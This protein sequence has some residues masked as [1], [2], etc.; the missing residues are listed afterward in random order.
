MK[1]RASGWITILLALLSWW[2]IANVFATETAGVT[3]LIS[4]AEKDEAAFRFYDLAE[5]KASL[6]VTI[7]ALQREIK[8]L[9]EERIPEA[10]RQE[11]AALEAQS[12]I[13]ELEK[14]E[15]DLKTQLKDPSLSGTRPPDMNAAAKRQTILAELSEVQLELRLHKRANSGGADSSQD[16]SNQLNKKKQELS[17]AEK[18]LETVQRQ[19]LR[20]TTPEQSFKA[21]ISVY[22]AGLI[23]FVILGFFFTALWDSKVRQSVFAGQAGIQF[24]AL[25]SII[26]AII[27]FGITGIL[28]GNELAALLGSISGYILGKVSNP[29]AGANGVTRP[30]VLVAPVGLR[31][32]SGHA[33]ELDVSCSPAA[34]ADSYVWYV[35]RAADSTFSRV[36]TTSS[37]RT[38]LTGF[39]A[40]ELIDV[41]VAAANASAEGPPSE[42]AQGNAGN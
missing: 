28:G 7:G 30:L 9:E 13:A 22:S 37:P 15:T 1:Y 32:L 29:N 27:L 35:K 20:I 12:A 3:N 16:L 31:A 17:Q 6:V 34:G 8:N 4:P 25:F 19:I 2:L 33:G 41:K 36:K 18:D 38:T 11:K 39:S 24:L 42:A 14:R 10:K 21:T 40:G 23:G 26:I 5:R